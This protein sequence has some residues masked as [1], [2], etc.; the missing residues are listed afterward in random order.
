MEQ[1]IIQS[2]ESFV[3]VHG[4]GERVTC[5]KVRC[6]IYPRI[7]T[8]DKGQDLTNQLT[9]LRDYAARS[10]WRIVGEYCDTAS[11]KSTEH[12]DAFKALMV[13]AAQR[14]F[15]VVLVWSLDRFSREGVMETFQHIERL[16]SYGV[17]FESLTEPHFRTTGPAGEL[18][19]AVA[20]WIAKQERLRIVERVRAGID[21]ARIKGTKSGQAI[22]RPRVIL[23]RDDVAQLRQDGLS[24]SQIA[25][26][27]G[28]TIGTVRRAYRD[29]TATASACQ[30]PTPG[31]RQ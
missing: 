23:R 9:P 15:D 19:L 16:K 30:N 27:T 25:A 26:A 2:I 3:P 11:G 8:R 21:R 1:K 31:V 13:D 14:K 18:M 6:A 22:G 29:Y 24:W 7:S 20:A 28:A 12:R 4:D 10:G 17:A 5:K